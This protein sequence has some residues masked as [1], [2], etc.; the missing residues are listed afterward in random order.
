[1]NTSQTVKHARASL[2]WKQW[3]LAFRSELN[4]HIKNDIFILKTSS[5]NRRI[6]ST[7]WVT[8][9]K[10]ELKEEMIKYKA[11]WVCKRFHQKQRIDYDEIFASMIRV[12]IIK[13]LLT[14]TVKYDYEVEQMNVIIAF[15]EAHLKKEIWVQQ[16]S[17]FE[18]KESN[19]TFLACCLNKTLYELKQTSREWYAILK[20]YL[21]FIDYQRIEIDHSVFIHDNEI[22]IAIY[23]NDLLILE[24]NIFDIEALKLQ[25]AERFQMKDLGSIK[26]YL[27][28]H[29]T[30]D[31]AEWTLWI[32]QSIYIKRVI[33]LLSM[34]NC[35]STKT[36]MHHRCQLKKNV[37]WKF[38]KWIEY[39]A[40]SEEIES[41]QSIIETLMW[42]VCQTRSDI[43]Y[44]VSKCSRYSTNSTFNHDLAVKQIIRYLV[45][46]A[47]LRLRYESFKVKRVEKAEFF[48]YIDS[49][50]AN[51]LDFRRFTFDYMF[52]LWNE[53]ISWSFKRQQCVST[54][55]AEAEYVNECNA[56]KKLTFLVQALK[57]MKYDGLNTNSTII[58]ADNQAAIKMSSNFVNH[59]RVK[60]ID[61]LYHYVRNKVEEKAIR[62]KYIL[63]DQMMIDDLIKSLKSGK[64]LRFRS[65][66]KLASRNE[67]TLIEH[68][69]DE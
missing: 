64:F 63:I 15:L 12:T 10:R 61:T 38:K 50:H 31:K 58:L 19:E 36:S 35:S 67:A 9:I 52:F 47:Q 26:W 24:S 8:I 30:C 48:E 53:S 43:V 11:R 22:I 5:S 1:M 54:S 25:F 17:K 3:K 13:M 68:D 7:R 69:V 39:Q 2:D 34:S 42:V 16:S 33:E 37:Y 20:V 59:L 55:S 60:H 44:A 57:E 18:Q 32:N 51:C 45:E 27:E 4:A 65:V 56:V 41:Y 40:I 23:V 66:M 21:I 6:L 49:A 62:L 14:L 28:M 29:I 46:T